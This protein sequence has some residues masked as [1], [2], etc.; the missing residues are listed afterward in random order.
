MLIQV[1]V[2]YNCL[3][4]FWFPIIC[5]NNYPGTTQINQQLRD[6]WKSVPTEDKSVSF[7]LT[8]IQFILFFLNF[9][10]SD[11]YTKQNDY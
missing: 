4:V 7:N 9:Y 10:F 3:Y 5:F 2:S 11:G 8:F 6:M 1:L